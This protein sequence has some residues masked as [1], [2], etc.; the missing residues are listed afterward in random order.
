MNLLRLMYSECPHSTVNYATTRDLHCP[1]AICSS[2]RDGRTPLPLCLSGWYLT[3]G[4][5]GAHKHQVDTAVAPLLAPR[6]A[7]GRFGEL[8]PLLGGVCMLH[9]PVPP[10]RVPLVQEG[11]V[12]AADGCWRPP[13]LA[14]PDGAARAAGLRRHPLER[15]R[16]ERLEELVE[17]IIATHARR[18]AAGAHHELRCSGCAA[19][20]AAAQPTVCLS[21]GAGAMCRAQR[22]RH[23][24]SW[25]HE[26]RRNTRSARRG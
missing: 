14:L 15:H 26:I 8:L 4:Q 6:G 23:W 21:R 10:A 19:C 13:R 3:V 12:V 1:A 7:L 9:P 24:G 17:L 11:S 22:H 18:E 5:N 2:K 25:A 16:G 20:A